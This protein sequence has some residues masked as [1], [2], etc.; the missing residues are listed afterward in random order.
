MACF[1]HGGEPG[2]VSDLAAAA[3]RVEEK[4]GWSHLWA[5]AVVHGDPWRQ[6]PL[7]E[8]VVGQ[9]QLET[10]RGRAA[11]RPSASQVGTQGAERDDGCQGPPGL[12]SF[13]V[14]LVQPF[15]A[16]APPIDIC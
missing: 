1:I 2:R 12:G 7:E 9:L 10:W 8:R 11:V 16:R 15:V 3:G 6:G 4:S 5:A 14:L 13:D